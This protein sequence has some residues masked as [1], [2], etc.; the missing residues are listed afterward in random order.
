MRRDD[1]YRVEFNSTGNGLPFDEAAM[2]EFRESYYPFHTLEQHAE[3]LAQFT[4]RFGHGFIEGY[5]HVMYNGE[6]FPPGDPEL[7]YD[8]NIVTISEGDCETEATEVKE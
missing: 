4:A 7:D 6:R 5:C 8:I 1:D 3:H 2:S